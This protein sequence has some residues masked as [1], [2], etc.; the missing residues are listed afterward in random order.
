VGRTCSTCAHLEVCR[1]TPLYAGGRAIGCGD[2]LPHWRGDREAVVGL[3]RETLE[4][5]PDMDMRNRIRA[6]LAALE[7]DRG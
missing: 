5:V 6:A 7:V 4:W 2:G 3:L 1:Y